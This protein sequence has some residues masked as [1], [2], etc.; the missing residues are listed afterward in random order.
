LPFVTGSI[1]HVCY[2]WNQGG[3][4]DGLDL[5]R[6][7]E[8]LIGLCFLKIDPYLVHESGASAE[9]T[10]A[11]HL[12]ERIPKAQ[13]LGALGWFEIV[14][15]LSAKSI[16]AVLKMYSHDLPALLI[17]GKLEGQPHTFAEKTV[18]MLG[19]SLDVS[20]PAL[21]DSR[22][23]VDLYDD[24]LKEDELSVR[25]ALS[26]RPSAMTILAEAV[27]EYSGSEDLNLRLG[28]RDMEFQLNLEGITTLNALLTKLD[29]LRARY[30]AS[31]LK[32]YTDLQ[33]QRH[34]PQGESPLATTAERP[35]E[36]PL[37]RMIPIDSKEAYQLMRLDGE[38]EAVCR[39]IYRYNNL[40]GN[41]LVAD[42][43]L[44][45]L[46][47]FEFLRRYATLATEQ[48]TRSNTERHAIADAVSL[49]SDAMAQRGEGVYT[50]IEEAPFVSGP[51][52][53]SMQ[54]ALK[55]MEAIVHSMLR[56]Q[57]K[58]WRGCVVLGVTRF[59]HVQDLV[60]VPSNA[61]LNAGRHW[62]I[63]HET[64]HVLQTLDH[65]RLSARQVF[66]EHAA[67]RIRA[68]NT[69]EWQHFVE[70]SADVLTFALTCPLDVEDYLR[71]FWDIL[72]R[73]VLEPDVDEQVRSYLF[74]SFSVV[75]YSDRENG[76]GFGRSAFDPEFFTD[77][78]VRPFEGLAACGPIGRLLV[79]DAR[80]EIPLRLLAMEFISKVGPWIHY[81]LDVVESLAGD[82]KRGSVRAICGPVVDDLREGRFVT[83]E[84]LGEHADAVSWLL[85]AEKE[86]H[87][88]GT[89]IAWILSLWN[90]Y[91]VLGLGVGYGEGA[92]SN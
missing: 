10:F 56:R 72:T 34:L 43:Y 73:E 19:H 55:G 30:G 37:Y 14:V 80:G 78:L 32:T 4:S 52:G 25:V 88:D 53:I 24:D 68:Q 59:E 26:C 51:T 35:A 27:K 57:N 2:T 83:A 12:R 17:A 3:E 86:P 54:R 33:Y 1:E 92:P 50:G 70:M 29:N 15:L 61:S 49:L 89:T 22:P 9:I 71:L 20:D 79:P 87:S 47:P 21:G 41:S 39:L 40:I 31:L 75:A 81:L 90:L 8:P 84:R 5:Q 76:I 6:L 60:I 23:S 85:A 28:T 69:P 64:M 48:P 38:G 91:H 16:G 46:R 42:A 7:D 62:G 67:P 65:K 44:D 18:S 74:R 11:N 58:N 63:A 36:R 66:P 13:V 45:L 82:R 77:R